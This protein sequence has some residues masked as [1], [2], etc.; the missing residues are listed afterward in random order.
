MWYKDKSSMM[1]LGGL[2][3]LGSLLM[4]DNLSEIQAQDSIFD[5]PVPI[6]T[7]TPTPVSDLGQQALEYISDKHNISLGSLVIGHEYQQPYPLS[8]L[9]FQAFTIIDLVASSD[10]IPDATFEY[11][12]LIDVETREVETDKAALDAAEEVAYREKYGKLEPAL[13]ERLQMVSDD[14]V[15]PIAIWVT[16]NQ[17]EAP[18]LDIYAILADEFPEAAEALQQGTKPMDVADEVVSQKIEARYHELRK[19]MVEV[20]TEPILIW[21][22]QEGVPVTNDLAMPSVTVNLSKEAILRLEKLDSVATIYLIEQEASPNADIAAATDRVT[23]VWNQGIDGSGVK[24]AIL[25]K[26]RIDA[27][28]SCLNIV[29][30][31]NVVST[32][33]AHK[34]RSASLVNCDADPYRG[35]AYGANLAD[36]DILVFRMML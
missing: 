24:V 33:D 5:S 4:T 1:I 19:G 23:T 11:N 13:Y 25:E 18:M 6:P 28:V 8:G 32:I 15:L 2:L 34:T 36:A 3:L 29:D 21:L 26:N 20:R 9:T 31:R 22:E 35:I 14:T 7:I 12:L 16:G 30:T 27:S 10:E 17:E